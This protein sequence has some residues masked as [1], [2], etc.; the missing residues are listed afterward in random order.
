MQTPRRYRA[1]VAYDRSK[2]ANLLFTLELQHRLDRSGHPTA[3]VA[4]HPGNA[5]TA[6]NRHMP[7]PFRGRSWGLARPM[8]QEA[9][10]GALSIV[11]AA[12]DPNAQGGEYFG[13]AG[14]KGTKGHPVRV[15][16]APQ[17]RDLDAARRLW[18]RSEELT[19]ITYPISGPA[20]L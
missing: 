15:E 18:D 12:T 2:L 11:R 9:A 10:I 6:L 1:Q 20:E 8:S 16:P 3:A 4:A 7:W 19:A 13:P 5:R 17:A 14:S